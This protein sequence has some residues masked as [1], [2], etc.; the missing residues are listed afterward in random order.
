MLATVFANCV[1]E[2]STCVQEGVAASDPS[3][4]K[5]NLSESGHLL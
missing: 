1:E 5:F 3:G 4:K 2:P